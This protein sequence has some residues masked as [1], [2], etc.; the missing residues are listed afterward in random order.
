ME[1][2]APDAFPPL[3]AAVGAPSGKKQRWPTRP[4]AEPQQIVEQPLAQPFCGE[5]A[6]PTATDTIRRVACKLATADYEAE[7]F[8][9]ISAN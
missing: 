1:I 3:T 5:A 2:F 6:P 9:Y 7:G 8:G 4:K